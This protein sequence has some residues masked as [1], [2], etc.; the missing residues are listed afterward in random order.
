MVVMGVHLAIAIAVF[1]CFLLGFMYFLWN[2]VTKDSVDYDL[3]FVW[4]KKVSR[5]Q[6]EFEHRN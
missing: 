5:E 1:A 6:I 3:I 2:V 4:D